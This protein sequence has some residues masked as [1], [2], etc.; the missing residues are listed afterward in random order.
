MRT[1]TTYFKF[2]HRSSVCDAIG[3]SPFYVLYGREPRLPIDVKLLPDEFVDLTRSVIKHRKRIVEKVEL[4]QNIAK[5]NL[6]RYQQKM[7][8]YYD[9]QSK[10]QISKLASVY[11]FTLLK[12]RKVFLGNYS[13]IG[14]VL[15][16]LLNNHLRFIFVYGQK[17]TKRSLLLSTPIE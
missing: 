13:I 5:E 16:E 7:K 12:L 8:D 9:H 11:G 4:V 3:D 10:H 17:I 6:Q 15:I 14:S 1:Y 2:A